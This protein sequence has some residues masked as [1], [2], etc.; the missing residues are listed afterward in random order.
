MNST[1]VRAL[2]IVSALLLVT[3]I[4]AVGCKPRAKESWVNTNSLPGNTFVNHR[5]E[6]AAKHNTA[7]IVY[8]GSSS[9]A[10]S[11]MNFG[12]QDVSFEFK[13]LK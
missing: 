4:I 10:T 9:D 7:A 2:V 12:P 13:S 11:D 1:K 5:A 8:L 3:S 6:S